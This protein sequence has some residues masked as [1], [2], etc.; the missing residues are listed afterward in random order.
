MKKLLFPTICV[1]LIISCNNKPKGPDVSGIKVDIKLERFEKDFFSIDTN[2]I[3]DDL[4]Q[5]LTKYPGFYADFMQE[6][7]GISGDPSNQ[8]EQAKVKEFFA[9][10][11]SFNDS[12]LLKYKSTAGIEK[13]IKNGLQH[14]KYYFPDYKIPGFITFLSTLDG[15]GVAFTRNYIA[16]GLQQY[17]GKDFT[18]YTDE[19]FQR[20]F[21][22]YVSRRFDEEYIAPN[23]MKAIADELF[24]DKSMGKPLIEQMIEKGKQ[25]YLVDLF[26]PDAA[27]SVK[28]GYTGKQSDWCKKNE[29]EIWS[30]IIKNEDLNSVN[31]TVI[32]T[33]IGEGPFTQGFSQENS[34]GNLG[35]WFGWQ[36]VKKYAEKNPSLKPEEIMRTNARKILDEAKYKPM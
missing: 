25:W 17:A 13:E 14:V 15:P 11:K 16:I 26:L 2:K 21:P 28:T 24:P 18:P 31:P 1:L 30:T 29:G 5:L 35:Q 12:L 27:D 7:L 32:Q 8:Q 3:S 34:P 19:V 22:R 33:Y 6:M 23:C 36:I 10:Y 9:A 20:L 4:T